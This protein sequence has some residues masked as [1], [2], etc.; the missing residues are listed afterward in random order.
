MRRT[1]HFMV[2]LFGLIIFFHHDESVCAKIQELSSFFLRICI[3]H[4]WISLG[5]T[6]S[7]PLHEIEEPTPNTVI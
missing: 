5:V 6:L 4:S 1:I 2:K 3:L 7:F